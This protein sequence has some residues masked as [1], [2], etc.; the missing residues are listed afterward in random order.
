MTDSRD[1]YRPP[2]GARPGPDVDEAVVTVQPVASTPATTP[3]RRALDTGSE[4]FWPVANLLGLVI[5]VA[6][7]ALANIVPFNGQTTGEVLTK[8]PIHFQPAGWTFSI[9]SLIY[10]LLALFV[11]YSFLPP[12]RATRRVTRVA[13]AF[14]VANAANVAW[15]VLW[16][17]EQWAGTLVAMVVL[18]AALGVV[19]LG[20]RRGHGGR[21]QPPTAE[22]LMVWT[23]FSVYLGWVTVALLANVAVWLDRTGR[24]LWGM[25]PRWTA[26][27]LAFAAV[28]ATAVMA[29]WERDPAYALAVGWG[30]LGIAVEQWDRSKLVSGMAALAVVLVAA[31]AVFGSLL[32]FELRLTGHVLPSPETGRGRWWR[33]GHRDPSEARENGNP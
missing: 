4:W 15:I 7:N 1:E 29:I 3:P 24:E 30:L 26:V 32:A 20:L 2:D 9:W 25:D 6:V 16:H 5:V 23:P 10:L 33:F 27:T 22:R 31:L 19:Y 8:D 21:I 13:P 18:V 14:L 11:V 17:W 28:L 12:G